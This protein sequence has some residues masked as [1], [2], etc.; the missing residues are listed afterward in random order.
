MCRRFAVARTWPCSAFCSATPPKRPCWGVAGH[1]AHA[2]E[3]RP[4]AAEAYLAAAAHFPPDYAQ[5][6]TSH[7]IPSPIGIPEESPL[8]SPLISW[9]VVGGV[10]SSAVFCSGLAQSSGCFI[11]FLSFHFNFSQLTPITHSHHIIFPLGRL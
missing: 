3:A 5:L 2:P 10:F 8:P 11:A 1:K 6:R 4:W 9:A 7:G